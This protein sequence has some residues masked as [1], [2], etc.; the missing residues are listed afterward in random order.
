MHLDVL[1]Q[2]DAP[3]ELQRFRYEVYVKELN[4]RQ[5][6]ANHDEQTIS[7]PL[8]SFSTNIVARVDRD[9]VACL[10]TSFFRHGDLGYYKDFYRIKDYVSALENIAI[11]TQLMISNRQRKYKVAKSLCEKVYEYGL[12]N[13]IR[14]CFIDCNDG[15]ESMF[16]KMGFKTL[17]KDRHYDYGTVNVMCLDLCDILYLEDIRSPFATMYHLAETHGEE[18]RET[19]SWRIQWP[20]GL[21]NA[22]RKR[23]VRQR[24]PTQLSVR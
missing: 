24:R 8:D 6:H 17:F 18:H 13:G 22:D 9:I 3:W 12:S 20:D 7:D 19:Y 2:G 4:R 16:R 10:R 21:R 14:H 11:V 23:L 1:K 15:L 5:K